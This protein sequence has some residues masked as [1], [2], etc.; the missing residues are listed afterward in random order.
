MINEARAAEPINFIQLLHLTGDFHG[1]RFILQDW[2]K[3]VI[4]NVY[5]TIKE[6]G[7]RQYREGYLEIPKK[8]GKTNLIAAL[9]LYHLTCD[10][11]GGEIYCCAAEKDR[12]AFLIA[13]QK[14]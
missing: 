5:G 1:K 10:P 9:G 11:P 3:E 4:Q 6:D 14:K 12:Q 8:N 13:L 2:Q 7:F